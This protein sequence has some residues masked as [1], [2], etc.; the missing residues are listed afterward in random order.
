MGHGIDALFKCTVTWRL[1]GQLC[2]NVFFFRAKD[3]DVSDTLDEDVDFMPNDTKNWIVNPMLDFMSSDCSLVSTEVVTVFPLGGPNSIKLW[4]GVVGARN[5]PSLPSYVAAVIST[6][7]GFSGR[8]T[9]GRSY[10]MG[11]PGDSVSGNDLS[12]GGLTRLV[13]VA[14]SWKNRYGINGSSSRWWAVVFSKKNGVTR[15]PGP[16]PVLHYLSLAGIPWKYVDARQTLFT[17]RHRLSGR[18]I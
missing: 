17:Q 18:G 4:D 11:V 12:G 9:H 5:S 6:H 7:T 13:N 15:D 16:P 2:Q 3:T 1:L 8:R 10:V 14:T